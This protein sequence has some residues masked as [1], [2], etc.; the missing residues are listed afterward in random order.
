MDYDLLLSGCC[1]VAR[2]LLRH[3]A[4]IQRVEDT[5]RRILAAYGLEGDV[6]AIPNCVWVST[7]CPDGRIRTV[8]RRVPPSSVDI[9]G[10]ERFNDLSR[11]LCANRPEDPGEI[12]ALCRETEAELRRY[13]AWL[14]VAGYFVGAFF[15]ALF[16][17]GGV[18]EAV[19]AGLAGLACGVCLTILGRVGANGFLTT[20]ASAFVLGGTAY[21]IGA[22]GASISLEITIAGAIMVL[23]PGLVFTNFMSDLLTGDMVAGLATFARAVLSAGAIA[24]GAGIAMALFREA[25]STPAG[26][27][28]E[29]GPVLYCVFAFVACL[30]FCPAFNAQG[31]GALLCCLGGMLG[32][33]VYLLA[34][35]LGANI[36]AA[37]LIAA[38][39]V[40][41]W[42]EWMARRR[43][44]P[45][46]SYLVIAMFPL[47][48]GLTI[49]QAMDYGLRGDTDLFL[50]TFFR[51][52]GI[53]GCLAL[54]LL[55]VS[56]ALG[57]MRRAKR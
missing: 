44:C 35:G 42:S 33:A 3:G 5:A 16:F 45:A 23:V 18:A 4:E 34:V 28:V 14:C 7:P 24:L 43:R 21:G 31:V 55:L 15:F 48:P 26:A 51:T 46:T 47:V 54:G 11:R 27:A 30:G 40:S 17:S 6:F 56:S 53:A 12:L 32:W 22:L 52:V 10:I 1:E 2:Q 57:L 41:A 9:E 19:A 38:M 29:Y 20:L 50:A 39:A 36:F 37:S 49:Y 13:P 8:M 25:A